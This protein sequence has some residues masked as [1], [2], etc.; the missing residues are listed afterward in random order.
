ILLDEPRRR[1]GHVEEF[2]E[3][4]IDSIGAS[5]P[6]RQGFIRPGG[7]FTRLLPEPP[8]RLDFLAR[9]HGCLAFSAR[10]LASTS[11]LMQRGHL[12]SKHSQGM[13]SLPR[14][15][16]AHGGHV[17][18]FTSPSPARAARISSTS[19]PASVTALWSPSDSSS[20]SSGTGPPCRSA[21]PRA[22]IRSRPWSVDSRSLRSRAA[23]ARACPSACTTRPEEGGA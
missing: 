9:G 6:C 13:W 7:C 11:P 21:S 10:S 17:Q 5:L 12:G 20:R 8:Q 15:H 3:R 23:S 19:P 4:F 18:R 22:V 16:S 14:S 2:V 1:L